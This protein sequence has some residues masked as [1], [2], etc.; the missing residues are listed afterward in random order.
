[1]LDSPV[2]DWRDVLEH[3]ADLRGLPRPETALAIWTAAHR[4]GVDFDRL[5]WVTR[6][7]ELTIPALLIH[8]DADDY[9]PDRPSKALAQQL[10]DLVTLELVPGA[11]HTQGWNTDPAGYEQRLL[12]WLAARG[13]TPSAR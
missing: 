8:S 2:L 6:A 13:A 3:Q 9:V 10:P 7:R 11:G 1:V 5:D 4:F 12:G